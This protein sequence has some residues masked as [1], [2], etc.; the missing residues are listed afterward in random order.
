M[1]QPYDSYR[2]FHVYEHHGAAF[3]T[4]DDRDL[5]AI[6]QLGFK[7]GKTVAQLYLNLLLTLFS[8]RF[9]L[10]FIYGR[11]KSNLVELPAWRRLM[12]FCWWGV[13]V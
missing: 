11:L 5:A 1:V 2:Q 13:L 9:Q 6:Y 8:P 7:L 10:T 4:F 3:S 12:T